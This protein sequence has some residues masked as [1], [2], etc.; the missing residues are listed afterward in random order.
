MHVVLRPSGVLATPESSTSAA[1][2]KGASSIFV[3]VASGHPCLRCLTVDL[4]ALAS[5]SIRRPDSATSRRRRHRSDLRPAAAASCCGRSSHSH[6]SLHLD[7]AVLVSLP[8]L[9]LSTLLSTLMCSSCC[10]PTWL[11]VPSLCPELHRYTQ[12]RSNRR[13]P[14]S[15]LSAT[16][17]TPLPLNVDPHHKTA[18]P[19]CACGG[20]RATGVGS[21]LPLASERAPPCSTSDPRL[22]Q[23]PR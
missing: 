2:P 11:I 9:M 20:P 23:Q 12:V 18:T 3:S 19:L 14:A 10:A 17:L 16:P 1:L 8:E 21:S 13:C 6:R 4:E 15:A 22:R 5:P 7:V